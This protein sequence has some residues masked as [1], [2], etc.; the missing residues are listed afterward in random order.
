[1]TTNEDDVAALLSAWRGGDEA[2]RDVLFDRIYDEL[3]TIASILLRREDPNIS[4]FTGDLV[5]E[6][7]IRLL[8]TSEI[9][10]V[11]R[12]HLLALSAHVMR[13]VLLDAARSR[14]RHKRNGAIVTLTQSKEHFD[15]AGH[16][17][18]AL[19]RALLRLNVIDP[20]RAAIVE[21]RYFAGLTIEEIASVQ[22]V[23]AATVKRR[24][25]AA[26]LWLREAIDN[27]F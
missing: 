1:M 13:H 18:L 25:D 22:N 2:A 24:W 16:E 6:A 9:D 11:D 27:D 21:M 26:R 8:R 5:N 14:N 3:A 15:G 12:N 10:V 7:I 19:D 20:E 23:S 4:I 17:M